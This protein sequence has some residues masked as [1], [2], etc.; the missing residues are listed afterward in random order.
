MKRELTNDKSNSLISPYSLKRNNTVRKTALN[1]LNNGIVIN[2]KSKVNS[3]KFSNLFNQFKKSFFLILT[4][5]ITLYVY[6]LYLF[7]RIFLF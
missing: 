1:K 2:N 3:N 6:Y 7:V 5:F 4:I